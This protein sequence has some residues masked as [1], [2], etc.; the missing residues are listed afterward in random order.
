MKYQKGKFKKQSLLKL[1]QKTKIGI[2]VT[3]K[4]KD[5]NAEKYKTLLKEIKDDSKNG[6]IPHALGMEELIL[7]K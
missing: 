6:K 3:K 2:K 5:L 1:H 4:M 7:L